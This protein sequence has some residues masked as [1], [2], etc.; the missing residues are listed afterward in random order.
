MVA[1]LRQMKR[2]APKMAERPT[3]AWFH[4]E[5][6]HYPLEP[7]EPLRYDP[8]YQGRFRDAFTQEDHWAFDDP[9]SLRPREIQHVAA[10]YDASI[11]D[12]DALVRDMLIMLDAAGATERTIVVITADHGE[13]IG[14]HDFTLEHSALWNNVLHVPLFLLWPGHF[15]PGHVVEQRVQLVD[16][17]PTLLSLAGLEP[18]PDLDGRDLSPL[19]RGGSLPEAPAYAELNPGVWAQYRGDEKFVLDTRGPDIRWRSHAMSYGGERLYDVA[20]DPGELDDLARRE[21]ARLADAKAALLSAMKTFVKKADGV[22]G[23]AA[24]QAA[25]E[26]MKQAGYLHPASAPVATH[27]EDR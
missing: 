11:R 2:I 12:A 14:E 1:I 16:L 4:I 19:L 22:R 8:G 5:N 21:P 27:L 9:R 3:F 17:V 23:A 24:G 25:F 15:P 18:E 7:S 6:A 10:L 20:R 13:N 26:M